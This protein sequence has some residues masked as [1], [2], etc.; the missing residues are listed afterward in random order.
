MALRGTAKRISGFIKKWTPLLV[1]VFILFFAFPP[2]APAQVQTR[3]RVI[4]A[5]NVGS[6]ID[7]SLK[8]LHGQL[9]SLFRYTSYRL[10]RDERLNLSPN[11]PASVP[12]HEGRSIEIT[13]V[14]LQ[15]NLVEL[16]VTIK[17]GGADLLNTQVRLSPGRTVL[18]GGPKHGEG[19]VILA[20][21]ANF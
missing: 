4:E 11:Q 7:P 19:V 10:L 12:V 1:F 8:E 6:V 18:I 5:S 16:R 21:S 3:L 13:Q 9:G 2:M 17:R 20:L 14:G 15:A